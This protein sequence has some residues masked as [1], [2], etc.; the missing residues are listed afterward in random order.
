MLLHSVESS[1]P[2]LNCMHFLSL[3]LSENQV[4]KLGL[5]EHSWGVSFVMGL[6]HLLVLKVFCKPGVI[7]F[8]RFMLGLDDWVGFNYILE[9]GRLNSVGHVIVHGELESRREV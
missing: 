4:S 9:E 2:S 8:W 7:C 3:E 6:K 1:L 5:I